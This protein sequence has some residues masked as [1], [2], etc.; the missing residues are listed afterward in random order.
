MVDFGFIM[1]TQIIF[2]NLAWK[3]G[4]ALYSIRK[5]ATVVLRTMINYGVANHMNL[6][7][8]IQTEDG[9][10]SIALHQLYISV[11]NALDED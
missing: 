10:D 7:T 4:K 5:S 3:P 1:L 2:T 6:G 8:E 11:S 9:K